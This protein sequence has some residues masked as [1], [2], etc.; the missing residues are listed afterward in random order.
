MKK[1]S[2]GK[3]FYTTSSPVY[4]QKELHKAFHLKYAEVIENDSDFPEMRL[5][6]AIIICYE[7]DVE[8]VLLFLN[9]FDYEKN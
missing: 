7:K 1:T 5:V 4:I 8:E 3:S 9:R 6:T 2:L